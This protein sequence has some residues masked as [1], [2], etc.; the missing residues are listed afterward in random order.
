[1]QFE[2]GKF[3]IRLGQRD[4]IRYAELGLG[5]WERNES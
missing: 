4:A 2:W 1:M 3:P 5:T